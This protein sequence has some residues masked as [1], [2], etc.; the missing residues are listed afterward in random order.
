MFTTEFYAIDIDMVRYRQAVLDYLHEINEK[1]GQ[2]WLDEVIKGTP[3]PSW[4]GASR[5]TFQKLARELNTTVPI[6][7]ARGAPNRIALGLS[8]SSGSGTEER[9]TPTDVYVGF[10][11][12]S[13]LRYLAYNEY[14]KAVAGSPPQPYSNNV[15]FTPYGFQNRASK[16]W[17]ATA[18]TARLPN[19]YDFILGYRI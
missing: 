17:Q 3:I 9:N 11:Y 2:A 6:R 10:L 19:P 5:A 13:Q 7:I 12:K 4:S 15:R 1:A 16:V 8:N 14:N 18:K